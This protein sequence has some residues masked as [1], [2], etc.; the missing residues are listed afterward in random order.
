M[1]VVDSYMKISCQEKKQADGEPEVLLADHGNQINGQA[2]KI[3]KGR[4]GLQIQGYA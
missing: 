3:E 4:E 1:Q 2:G